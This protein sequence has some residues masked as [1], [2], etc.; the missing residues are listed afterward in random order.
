MV[1]WIWRG[2][3]LLS[4]PLRSPPSHPTGLTHLK[5]CIRKWGDGEMGDG[6]WGDEK[7]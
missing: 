4:E 3:P 1:D 2:N 5:W 6:G 7:S